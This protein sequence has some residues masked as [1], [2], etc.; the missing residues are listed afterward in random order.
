MLFPRKEG[1]ETRSFLWEKTVDNSTWN[2]II[3]GSYSSFR[4]TSRAM[5]FFT[6]LDASYEKKL[7]YV[8]IWC[9]HNVY[10]SVE[11]LFCLRITCRTFMMDQVHLLVFEVD[12][13]THLDMCESFPPSIFWG[14]GI[15]WKVL[16]ACS[17]LSFS[18]C[19]RALITEQFSSALPLNLRKKESLSLCSWFLSSFKT[20]FFSLISLGF[21][22]SFLVPPTMLSRLEWISHQ[23]YTWR[24]RILRERSYLTHDLPSNAFFMKESTAKKN[25]CSSFPSLSSSSFV[26]STSFI[27][28]FVVVHSRLGLWSWWSARNALSF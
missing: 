20:D 12:D 23:S 28:C 17:D 3:V 8:C 25:G 4:I 11:H 2:R 22:I 13:L 16:H 6:F 21:S 27:T 24:P 18:S 9:Q 19:L 14:I 15:P 7:L 1:G 26:S 5:T 10:L